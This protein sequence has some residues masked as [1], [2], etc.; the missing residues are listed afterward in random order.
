MY[1]SVS[2]PSPILNSSS[3]Y[4]LSLH[5]GP[6]TWRIRS[7][8]NPVYLRLKALH[9][10]IWKGGMVWEGRGRDTA[11]GGGRERIVGVAY[12]GVGR[13]SLSW[14]VKG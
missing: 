3:P 12:D 11:L 1:P 7:V 14:E 6:L 9:N 4:N 5:Q 10:V 2:D 8:G 13:S